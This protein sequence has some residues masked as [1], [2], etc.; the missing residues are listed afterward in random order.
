[1]VSIIVCIYGLRF[2]PRD[3][4]EFLDGGGSQTCQCSKYCTLDFCNL[5]I[6]NGINKSILRFGGMI[7]KFLS[8]VFLAER[9]NLIE[10][11]LQ[12]M[13]HFCSKLVLR[14]ISHV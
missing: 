5:C 13:G 4:I 10:V 11:H 3:S 12:I 14:S 1:M 8:C 7:L 2:E 6:L 9:R